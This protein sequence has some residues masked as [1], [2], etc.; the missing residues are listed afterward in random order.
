MFEFF[1]QEGHIANGVLPID[2]HITVSNHNSGVVLAL[3]LAGKSDTFTH[4]LIDLAA[5]LPFVTVKAAQPT[6]VDTGI[7]PLISVDDGPTPPPK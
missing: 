2:V 4:L 1:A 3:E 6:I 7:I 5:L